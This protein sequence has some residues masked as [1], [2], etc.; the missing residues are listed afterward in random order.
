MWLSAHHHMWDCDLP[1]E[2]CG[3]RWEAAVVSSGSFRLAACTAIMEEPCIF[4]A[5]AEKKVC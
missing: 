4:I 5:P 2:G 1:E 3:G